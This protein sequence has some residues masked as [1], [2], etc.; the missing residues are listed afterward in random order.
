[1]PKKVCR[2]CGGCSCTG[3][4]FVERD[5]CVNCYKPPQKNDNSSDKGVQRLQ[6]H[7]G[8]KMPTGYSNLEAGENGV[9][10]QV[11]SFT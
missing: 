6:R 8:Y 3:L 5:L 11:V 7:G 2:V 1:M 4:Q 10:R 9:L